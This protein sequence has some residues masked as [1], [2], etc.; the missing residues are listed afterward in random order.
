V[1]ICAIQIT[2]TPVLHSPAAPVADITSEIQV[3]I[4]DMIDTMHNAP[5]V[6]L[7]APQVFVWH[8]DDGVRLSEGEVIN[9][10]LQLSGWRKDLLWGTPAEEGCLSVPGERSPLARYPRAVLS[11]LNRMG[12]PIR[13]EAEGWLARIFQHE[14]DHLYG[15]LYRDRLRRDR[16]RDIDSAVVERGWGASPSEWTPGPEFHEE[17]W[18]ADD[19]GHSEEETQ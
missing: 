8:Y 10:T 5:G 18:A 16:R 3:L 7:A 14:F 4:D 19:L 13:V 17:D 15:L 12:E 1:S 11:G 2:G 6:G 9:P